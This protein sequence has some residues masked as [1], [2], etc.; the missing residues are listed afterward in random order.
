MA[1][2]MDLDAEGELGAE[3]GVK[4]ELGLVVAITVRPCPD[5]SQPSRVTTFD[6]RETKTHAVASM[7]TKACPSGD[8]M[9]GGRRPGQ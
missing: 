3:G 2:K 4:A 7:R 1:W 5:S 6:E 8:G 9:S